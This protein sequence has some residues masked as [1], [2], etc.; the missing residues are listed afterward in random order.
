MKQV[1]LI[2]RH[3]ATSM[4]RLKSYMSCIPGNEEAVERLRGTE[5]EKRLARIVGYV[6]Q[7]LGDEVADNAAPVE[8]S[9]SQVRRSVKKASGT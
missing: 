7:E 1:F 6:M 5:G 2:R 4:L 9:Q 3:I 8:S